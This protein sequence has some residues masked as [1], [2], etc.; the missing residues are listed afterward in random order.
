[1]TG[2]Q[3]KLPFQSDSPYCQVLPED[4]KKLKVHNRLLLFWLILRGRH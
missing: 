3:Q 4:I 2:L 1:M